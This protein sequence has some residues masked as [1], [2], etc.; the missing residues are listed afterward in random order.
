MGMTSLCNDDSMLLFGGETVQTATD[1]QKS[2]VLH[3]VSENSF[4]V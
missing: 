1:S 4:D 3:K 2:F